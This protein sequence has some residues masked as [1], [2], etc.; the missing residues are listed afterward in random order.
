M[1][2]LPLEGI[3]V[4]DFSWALSGPYATEWLSLLGAEVIK[5]ESTVRP[6]VTRNNPL[7]SGSGLNQAPGFNCLGYAKKSVTINL[8]TQKGIELAKKI[9]AVSDVVSDSFA[10]G[11]M[12]RHGLGYE[13]LKKI[14]PDLIVFS[15]NT[16]GAYGR[17]RHLFGWGTAVIS[18]AGLVSITG[19]GEDGLPQMM[20]GT[21]PDYTLGNY[22]P[23]LIMAALYYRQKTGQGMFLDTAMCDA[24]VTMIPEAVMDYT[25]NG[26]VQEARGNKDERFAP[27]G[28]YR[29]IGDD[30][31][32]AIVIEN[33]A[34]WKTF[35][36]LTG[37][38]HWQKDERLS[39]LYGRQ[40]NRHEL[41][42]GIDD[43][44]CTKTA[45]EVTEMLQKAG[46]PA[47][48]VN[49]LEEVTR[50]PHLQARGLFKEI[51]HPEVGTKL[52]P[53][54]PM[55]LSKV[56]DLKYERAP[57]IGEHNQYVFS[58]LCGISPSELGQLVEERVII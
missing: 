10:Y 18:Y 38:E 19:Y 21:W 20:G 47:S 35:C 3:R 46:I 56:P 1:G 45:A 49:N 53:A 52:S 39:D 16:M 14:K 55:N 27:H 44:T 31:W 7:S 6:D 41:D 58:E 34:E 40:Q 36:K 32:V 8:G 42:R 29:C 43:W 25:M 5:I 17:E 30:K 4:A 37:R 9:I 28:V 54:T 57:L 23:F 50:D 12:E 22:S 2:R 24:V 51:T 15:K 26:R 13:E 33:D 11:V 48:P